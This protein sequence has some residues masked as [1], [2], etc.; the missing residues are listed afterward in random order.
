VNFR[1]DGLEQKCERCT[2]SIVEGGTCHDA[3]RLGNTLYYD[4]QDP[5]LAVFNPFSTCYYST[6]YGGSDSSATVFNGFSMEENEN[7]AIV[8]NDSTGS[9][10]ACGILKKMA[11]PRTYPKLWANLANL[12]NYDQAVEG[13][14]RVDFYPDRAF[15]VDFQFTG[16]PPACPMCAI[17]IHA[18]TSCTDPPGPPHWNSN[19]MS[20]DPWTFANGAFYQS[21]GTGTSL[22]RE[23]FF[24][25][26]GFDY[27]NHKD[28]VVIVSDG[29][30]DPIACGELKESSHYIWK[31]TDSAVRNAMQ[32]GTLIHTDPTGISVVQTVN[33]IENVISHH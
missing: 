2:W 28:R 18:G 20:Q 6:N 16:A 13:K 22:D 21:D 33:E 19:K 12:T 27:D 25:Y 15:H 30:G 10:L 3:D 31:E 7:R 29:N 24:L 26:D 23:G 4:R 1:V 11:H 9:P 14:I 5:A 32:A 17:A 8:L